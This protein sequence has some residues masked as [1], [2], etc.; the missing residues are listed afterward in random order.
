MCQAELARTA[1]TKPLW[2]LAAQ[3]RRAFMADNSVARGREL[4][5]HPFLTDHQ[6]DG[7]R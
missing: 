4:L 1:R 6:A 2:F 3:A 5:R 7:P